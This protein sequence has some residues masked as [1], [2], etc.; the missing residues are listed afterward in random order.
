MDI[1]IPP[2]LKK[3][4]R[5]RGTLGPANLLRGNT[6]LNDFMTASSVFLQLSDLLPQPQFSGQ[7]PGRHI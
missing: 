5:R 3:F 1:Q 2:L 6:E 4:L 7:P